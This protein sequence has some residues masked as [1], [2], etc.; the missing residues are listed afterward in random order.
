M[1]FG[2]GLIIGL[3]LLHAQESAMQV[4]SAATDS[5]V[6]LAAD[7]EG[8]ALMAPAD[9]PKNGTFWWVMAGGSPVPAPCPPLDLSAPIYQLANGQFL[10]DETGGQVAVN[11]RRFGAQAQNTVASALAAQADAVVNLIAQAQTTAANQQMRA[12]GMDIP[13]F[14]GGGEGGDGTNNFY[15]DSFNF[16][17]DYGTNL[18]IAQVGMSSGYLMGILSNSVADIQYE[19]QSKTDLLQT[20]WFSEGFIF[21]SELTNWTPLSV[22]QN[23]R[24]NLFLR[25]RSWADSDNLGIPDWWQFQ[26]F[27][28]NGIDPYGDPTGDG[29]SN[30]Q[31]FQNGMNPN[32][33][34]TP[35]TPSGFSALLAANQTDILLSWN[36]PPGEPVQHYTIGE[37]VYSSA[38]W[39][40]TYQQVTQLDA[41][42]TTFEDAGA[43]DPGNSDNYNN[44]FDIQADYSGGSSPQVT[45][46]I[47]FGPASP[48]TT[49]S[50]LNVTAQLVRNSTGHWQLMFSGIPTTVQTI[51]LY[52][53]IHDYFCEELEIPYP[54]FGYPF[55]V[56]TDI[57]TSSLTN[58]IY[59]IPD[60]MTTNDI[61]NNAYGKVAYIQPIGSDG[62][63][64]NLSRAG[65]LPYDA[66]C[67]VDGR[68]HLKQNL[69]FELRAATM[70]MPCAS[71]VE[72]NIYNGPN[73]LDIGIPADANVVESS[74]LHWSEMFKGY[75]TIGGGQ[76]VP[77]YVKMDD[78]WPITA[79]YQLHQRLYDP[80]YTGPSDF[81]WQTNL[82]AV[83]ASAVLGIGDPYWIS[84]DLGYLDDVAAYASNNNL[85]LESGVN[86]LFGVAFKQALVNNGNPLVT[87]NPGGS[88]D[89]ANVNC[90]Y[91]QTA[92]PSLQLVNYYFAPVVTPGTALPS[93]FSP[94]QP[95][96]LP[97]LTGFAATNQTGLMI[98][99][100]GTPTV[101]G[102]WAK[103]SIQNGSSS[104]FA[105]LGQYFV[106][107][108]FVVNASGGVTAN[109]T[110]VVS[111]YGEFFPTDPGMVAMM[112][113]PDLDTGTQGTGAVRVV[114]LN[115]D[116]NRDG[117]MDFK[118]NSP[119]FVSASKPFR[120]WVND[121]QD[122][123][124]FGGNGGIPGLT[125]PQADGQNN[126]D[127]N[128]FGPVY[129]IHGTRDLVD[130]FPVYLNIGSLFQSNI[131]SAGIS[132]TDTNWQFV[133]SQSDGALR[134]AYTDLTPT[135]YMNFLRD[136][137]EAIRLGDAP[138]PGLWAGALLTTI[139]ANG[140]VLSNSFVSGIAT[141][142]QGIILVEAWTNTTSPLVLSVY[143]G[144][145]L[146][147]Q[148]SLYLSISGVEQMFR[149]KNLLLNVPPAKPDRLNDCG[150]A[151]RA[152]HD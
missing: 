78:L 52:W 79:N 133:L 21:G 69:L 121:D 53:Y 74:F 80:N 89:M 8:L 31:K 63:L 6:Q 62:Q 60:S 85:Y 138:G 136:T 122:S 43:Y 124:D 10:V 73:W 4:Q 118:Y 75:S 114:S 27:G 91:S 97:C 82:L 25:V 13:G 137:N 50:N 71:L 142:N 55:N 56:E 104:K 143:H 110:G 51:A 88:V 125:Y 151:E 61:P 98:A 23:G 72:L 81:V 47:N 128:F 119:D 150:C 149:H 5:I 135:N 44:Y 19:I 59:V 84:Q 146:L 99:S 140:V 126:L 116:A 29:W 41:S 12:M 67:F 145:N 57:P 83:P 11:P 86:N 17:P 106:T 68:Q 35:P 101:I 120:F 112:T 141:N 123:G 40:W 107:N 24:T 48:S 152:G 129:H 9:L 16:M 65:F 26:Y 90:F 95:A 113:M 37:Y 109:T 102:G 132:A 87:L 77:T 38:N 22:P 64:G 28:T 92:D 39:N 45:S 15:S 115:V 58:G 18:W 96:P 117:T 54:A 147:A 46:W 49:A 108:A 70:S 7:A 134:F 131:L 14:G 32:V 139:T 20:D 36:P 3:H 42:S 100:V 76:P 34:Y 93:E 103:F 30:L 1:L 127:W 66:P 148:T 94:N 130:F 144:T 33:F 2:G 111:P 105:Y